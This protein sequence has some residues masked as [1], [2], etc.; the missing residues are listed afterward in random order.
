MGVYREYIGGYEF[1]DKPSME[2]LSLHCVIHVQRVLCINE[3]ERRSHCLISVKEQHKG[4][5]M[6]IKGFEES[7][8]LIRTAFTMTS[9]K[10]DGEIAMVKY[11][12]KDASELSLM[13]SFRTKIV[14][15]EYEVRC[16]VMVA[17]MRKAPRRNPRD[18]TL[19]LGLVSSRDISYHWPWS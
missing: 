4:I 1:Y 16:I 19:L 9:Y 7:L 11:L 8:V 2:T 3:T 18:K 10:H 17:T 14:L 15:L 12:P 6:E 13:H 5:A